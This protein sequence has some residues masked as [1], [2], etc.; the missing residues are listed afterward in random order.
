MII[1]DGV[2]TGVTVKMC[3]SAR[4]FPVSIKPLY[5]LPSG[6]EKT[7][8]NYAM[9]ERKCTKNIDLKNYGTLLLSLRMAYRFFYDAILEM[10]Y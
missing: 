5:F 7:Y 9:L 3:T 4:I 10:F 6:N 1:T 2:P 8:Y